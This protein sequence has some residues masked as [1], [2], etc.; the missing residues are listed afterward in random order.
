MKWVKV[1]KGCG[2]GKG[3]V[4]VGSSYWHVSCWKKF[5]DRVKNH[6]RGDAGKGFITKEYKV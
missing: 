6:L 2:K 5:Q 1:C 3:V 4:P